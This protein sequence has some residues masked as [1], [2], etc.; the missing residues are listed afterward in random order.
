MG[1]PPIIPGEMTE[2][3]RPTRP[4]RRPRPLI[5]VALALLAAIA[6]GAAALGLGVATGWIDG[7]ETV[8]LSGTPSPAADGTATPAA[9]PADRPL[10]GGFDPE[11]IYRERAPGVVTV[12]SLFEDHAG[13]EIVAEGQGSGFVVSEDGY[14]L[15]NSHVITTAGAVEELDPATIDPATEVY[16]EFADRDRVRAQIV[17]WDLFY[18]IGVLKLDPEEHQLRPVPLGDS[19]DVEVG[20]PV[21]AIGSPFGQAG[22]LAVGVV[23]ATERSVDSLTS[24]YSVA[25]AIQTDAPINRGN[26]GGPLFN[27]RGEVI[28]INAQI[29]SESGNAEGVGFAIPINIARRSMEQLIQTGRVRYAWIG[30]ST[31]TLTP[32]IAAQAGMA[33]ESGAAVQCIVPGSPAARA[34]L[35]AGDDELRAQGLPFAA[36]GD[37]VVAINDETVTTSEDLG[38]IVASSLFPGET[39]SFTI[40]RD[41]KRIAV[42]VVLGDRPSEASA[43]C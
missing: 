29:R 24:A 23:S 35:K 41:G 11:A 37:V 17:G 26:S 8:V 5:V 1:E 32:S 3:D 28:G 15:T 4:D 31:Q 40:I 12:Y 2:P 6:G 16:V 36:G 22:S 25:D 21:A 20:E 39:V 38:R 42:P 14:V 43:S 27:E 33:V 10:S 7:G 13:T 19:R 18:D 9:V 30:I 34:G